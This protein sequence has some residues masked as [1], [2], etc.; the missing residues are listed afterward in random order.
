MSIMRDCVRGST[1]QGKDMTVGNTLNG[2]PRLIE[3][4]DQK[5]TEE[6]QE[7]GQ[8]IPSLKQVQRNEME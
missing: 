3:G 7:M 8:E 2:L 4:E 6:G 1:G 5:E